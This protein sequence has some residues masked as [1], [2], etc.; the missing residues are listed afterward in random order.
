MANLIRYKLGRRRSPLGRMSARLLSI[1]ENAPVFI[2]HA[3]A[4]D[5]K[6]VQRLEG[7]YLGPVY[8]SNTGRVRLRGFDRR[9]V[10]QNIAADPSF[11][12]LQV[13]V[14]FIERKNPFTRLTQLL[15]GS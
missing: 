12:E 15:G 8:D 5:G 1:P 14:R 10:G 4:D 2:T 11:L 9:F 6:V 3:T 7:I 13:E